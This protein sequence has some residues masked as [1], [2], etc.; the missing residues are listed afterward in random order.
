MTLITISMR[1][2][3]ILRIQGIDKRSLAGQ[4][5]FT[6][7]SICRFKVRACS[8]PFVGTRWV[9]WEHKPWQPRW[10][11]E[12]LLIGWLMNNFSPRTLFYLLF[13]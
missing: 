1:S 9:R 6:G 5:S 8:E 4:A 2:K 10:R 3:S 12:V 7:S 11:G 13:E